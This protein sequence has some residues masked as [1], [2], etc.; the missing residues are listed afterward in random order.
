MLQVLL[1]A[2]IIV[3]AGFVFNPFSAEAD[4]FHWGFKKATGGSSL[5]PALHLIQCSINMEPFTKES[6]TKKLSI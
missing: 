5:V 2:T 1:L 6:Q 3:M 4:E